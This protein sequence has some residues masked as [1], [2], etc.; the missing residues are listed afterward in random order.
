MI[1]RRQQIRYLLYIVEYG[2]IWDIR[3]VIQVGLLRHSTNM[4]Q[5]GPYH[6]FHGIFTEFPIDDIAAIPKSTIQ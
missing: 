5:S 2:S 1:V 4:L 6:L 3:S